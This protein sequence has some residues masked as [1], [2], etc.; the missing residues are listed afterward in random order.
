MT[1][2]DVHA[3]CIPSDLL[4]LLRADGSRFGIEVL[5]DEDGE[6]AIIADRVR[7][8]PFRAVLS[9]VD[10]RLAAMDSTGVDIQL[11][12]SWVDLTAYALEPA[13]GAD[14]ARRFNEIMA[15]EAAKHPGRFLA[16]GTV[17]LQSAQAAAE[18]LHHAVENL[19]MVGVEIATTV[20]GTDLDQAGLDPFWQAAE[21][22]GCLV[23]L[24]PC[25]PLP[26]VD[27][28]RNFLDNMVGR[29]AESTIALGHLI[30]SGVLEHHPGLVLCV[31]H[32]GGFL[33]YQLGRMERGYSAAPRLAA[34]NLS[35]PPADIARRLYY[36]TVLHDPTAL[37]FLV[38]RVGADRVV[39]GTDYP[40]PMGD[41]DPVTT[42]NGIPG[43]SDDQRQLI[44]EGNVAR[45]LEGIKR[46]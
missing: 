22:L 12:S 2:Y 6:S 17:P 4:G 14:Y 13:Q 23:L 45:I 7:L 42:V 16:L 21:D 5:S 39:M 24:H 33:P 20:D 35:T 40:F 29:P 15:A 8:A 38:E 36:D 10:A 44:L 19:G 31:V 32:G 18:E 9:D 46:S 3:H 41:P 28:Q 30:F 27:L 1:T 34:Q 11:L 37:A 25:D 26:G 43:L